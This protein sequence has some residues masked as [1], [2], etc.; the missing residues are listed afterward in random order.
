MPAAFWLLAV[1]NVL[2]GSMVGLERTVVPLLGR[3]V[4]GLDAGG[5]LAAF[6]I[7]FGISKAVFNLFAGAWADRIGRRQVL[8]IGW[9]LGLPIPLLLIW[10]PSWP[11][12]VAANVLLGANQALT[13]SMTVNMMVDLVP[14]NRRGFAAGINEFS[15]YAG[16]SVLAFLTGLIAA[17]HGLR[18]APFYLGIGVAVL[19]LIL[20]FL[21]RE[22]APS[23]K[24]SPLR[25]VR[26][27]GVPS[28]LGAA[29]NLKDGLVWLALPKLMTNAASAPPASSPKTSRPSSG[30]TVRSSPTMLPTRTLM[31]ASSQKA[32][33]T[34]GRPRGSGTVGGDVDG[35]PGCAP[36]R[37]AL[38]QAHPTS[39]VR[40]EQGE[41]VVGHDAVRPAAVGD[42]GLVGRELGEPGLELAHRDR[43]GAGDVT[44]AV[45]LLGADVDHDGVA[46]VETLEEG[47]G[48]DGL[49]VRGIAEVRDDGA[50]DLGQLPFAERADAAPHLDHLR[51]GEAVVHADALAT[52]VDDSGLLQDL[53]MLRGV[54][55][56]LGDL[57]RERVDAPLALREDVD[58]LEADG[59]REGLGDP[60]EVIEDG[61][62]EPAR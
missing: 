39:P 32:A 35:V 61:V 33:G 59:A 54:R 6:V 2:V 41:G 14:A 28:L 43:A 10:A 1:I 38:G 58:D 3:D 55:Q 29:T 12:I 5:A 62:L 48:R 56:R 49:E 18:P 53:E 25:W 24:P 7:S 40:L 57:V 46:G 22:T 34:R 8:R 30:T 27:V 50:V 36:V 11:W 51:I 17:D 21:V 52:G 15:G 19:G 16:L 45:L 60:G 9:L 20:S 37:Q 13:W 47:G 31:A 44:G 23:T 26:G 4:F 42:H